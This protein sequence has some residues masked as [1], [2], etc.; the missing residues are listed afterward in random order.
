MLIPI[1]LSG[2]AGKRLWPVSRLLHP[3]PFIELEGE[4]LL[5]KALI[6]AQNL[7]GVQEV[8]TVTTRELHYKT[9]DAYRHIRRPGLRLGY[10]LEPEGRNTAPAVVAAALACARTHPGAT[11]LFL[12][13][14]H[15]IQDVKAFSIAVNEAQT[16]AADWIVTFGLKPTRPETGYGYIQA[17]G[18]LVRRFVE[19]PDLQ[20]AKR[21]LAEGG[22]FWN[23]G[24]ICARVELL[25]DELRQHAPALLD[26]QITSLRMAVST[27]KGD[28]Y[29]LEL[30]SDAY[31]DVESISIDHALLEKTQRAA[32][33]GCDL[34]WTDVGTW[35][36]LAEQ[37]PADSQGNRVCGE[38]LLHDTRDCYIH[39][40]DRLVA[41]AGIQGLIVVDTP[42][43]LLIMDAT[44]P[45]FIEQIIERLTAQGHASRLQHRTVH[46]PWGTYT[47]LETGVGFKIKR[48]CVNPGASLSLQLHHHRSE[49][50][51]VVEGTASV[52][53]G[54][55]TATFE[56]NQST[57]IP[58][59]CLHKLGN[60]GTTPLVLIEVQS[61][62]YLEEDDILR[63]DEAMPGTPEPQGK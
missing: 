31:R 50:W 61:G 38:V 59:G 56:R 33:V 49:H 28:D 53:N 27:K 7:I 12:T 47:V 30:P 58:A 62:P 51:I 40:T 35:P 10:L 1:I 45:Q 54:E 52:V 46:R 55:Q 18:H 63:F 32:V 25:L 19:K 44:R 37:L 36:A 4:S 16:L 2:G 48:L 22:Y 39:A 6:R 24:M 21:Y 17:D 26:Q 43:A 5:Q 23:S 13:A 29:D 15:L 34:D 57:Y 20:T 3:K 42:D 14:D 9:R 60:P 41:T 11:L 8:V